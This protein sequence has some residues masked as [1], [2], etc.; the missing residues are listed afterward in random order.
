MRE[1]PPDPPPATLAPAF[2][3]DDR[4]F[5]TDDGRI[6]PWAFGSEFGLLRQY[7]DGAD[8]G[9]TL[10]QRYAT[11]Q[12][13][14]SVFLSSEIAGAE[15]GDNSPYRDQQILDAL[16]PFVDDLRTRGFNTEACVFQATSICMPDK[17][18]QRA[19]WDAV[20][21]IASSRPWMSVSVSK[22]WWKQL[23]ALDIDHLSRPAQTWDGGGIPD[24]GTQ[25]VNVAPGIWVTPMRGS[26]D[27][28]QAGRG[29]QWPR[30]TKSAMDI[31]GATRMGCLTVE[32][33][34]AA[35]VDQPGRR[36]NVPNDFFW[37]AANSRLTS[38]GSYFHSDAGANGG[39]WG[40]E[41]AK[42]AT[43]HFFALSLIPCECQIGR[44]AKALG[45]WAY[46]IESYDDAPGG[47]LRTYS[48]LVSDNEQWA[49]VTRPGP[50]YPMNGGLID[51][52]ILNDWRVVERLG[53]HGTVI[54]SVR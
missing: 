4:V 43:A 53:V 28:Y 34:G 41:Q 46:A 26:H 8:I 52:R 15:L 31:S 40:P 50:N 38:L 1:G 16:G 39:L 24:G 12:R 21:S 20:L 22:E 36:S 51:P 11:G 48:M 18:R 33:M 29:D 19:F 23:G 7:L 37:S 17:T 2:H 45:S 32:P 30:F 25:G 47:S 14:A 9:P 44:Y 3:R 27:T 6:F 10:A 5:R 13:G 35:E 54:H 49:V 42:C